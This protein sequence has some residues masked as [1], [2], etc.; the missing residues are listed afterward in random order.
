M[1]LEERAVLTMVVWKQADRVFVSELV[2]DREDADWHFAA[3]RA[4]ADLELADSVTWRKLP[5][6]REPLLKK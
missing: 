2:I 1:M 4:V 3:G 5:C 6:S